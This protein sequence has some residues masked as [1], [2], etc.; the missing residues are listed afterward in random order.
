MA[1]KKLIHRLKLLLNLNYLTIV[2]LTCKV[3]VIVLTFSVASTV[4]RF[5]ISLCIDLAA[6][7]LNLSRERKWSESLEDSAIGVH[8][9]L[10]I[11]PGHGQSNGKEHRN[12]RLIQL[13]IF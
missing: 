9:S 7:R 12:K 6:H 11:N 1:A 2:K 5:R 4:G 8:K 10:K 3:L 13:F